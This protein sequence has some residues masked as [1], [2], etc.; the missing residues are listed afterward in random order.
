MMRAKVD[1]SSQLILGGV[2][3]QGTS[4]YYVAREGAPLI[5]RSPPVKGAK[6]GEFKRR[7]GL[8]DHEYNQIAAT[9]PPGV[10]DE[11]IHTKNKSRHEIREF[12]IEAGWNVA[13]C[14]DAAA[15]RFDNLNYDYY[16]AEARKLI[17]T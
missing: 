8:T 3:I 6:V 7:S 12:G 2:Q 16:V 15:F 14:N 5:K 1:R 10:H 13:E 11:R 17:I 4:R 9:V